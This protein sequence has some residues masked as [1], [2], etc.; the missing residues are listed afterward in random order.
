M[1]EHVYADILRP[2]EKTQAIMYTLFLVVTGTLLLTLSAKLQLR[3]GFSIPFTFQTMV[4]T[5]IGL[6]YGKKMGTA[7]I[8]TYIGSGLIGLPVFAG[9]IAGPAYF[10]GPTAGYLFGFII[11]A[12]ITGSLA[13]QGWDRRWSTL[14]ATVLLGISAIFTLGLIWLTLIY[15][16]SI[17]TS[18]HIGLYP[19]IG[20]EIIKITLLTSVLPLGWKAK[21]RF[22]S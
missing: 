3:I 2:Q 21:Q 12:Y 19:F 4:V 6:I 16:H 11:A 9:A 15:T 13:E 10:A 17:S 20:G 8:V 7:T 22:S 18:L 14:L 5:L 1:K